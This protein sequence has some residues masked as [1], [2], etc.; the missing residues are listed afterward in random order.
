MENFDQTNFDDSQAIRVKTP[1]ALFSKSSGKSPINRLRAQPSRSPKSF[2]EQ[3]CEN[4]QG[5]Q[6]AYFTQIDGERLHFCEKCAITLASTGHSIS[7]IQQGTNL[8]ASPSQ[9]GS[10][11]RS[12]QSISR[13][14]REM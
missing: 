8:F 3:H 4:H 1:A 10:R 2:L 13:N 6:A 7:R 12:A 9:G 11:F 5:K 14:P